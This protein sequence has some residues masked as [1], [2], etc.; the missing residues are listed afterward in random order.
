MLTPDTRIA[1]RHGWQIDSAANPSLPILSV[2]VPTLNERDN[3]R[4]IV[5]RI[6]ASLA[7]IAWEVVFVDDD[8]RDGTLEVLRELSRADRRV[9][10]L[11][12]IGRRGLSSAVCEGI[13]STST[14]FVAVMDCDLQ[15][16][17]AMLPQMLDRLK[18]T[19]GDIVVASRYMGTGGVGDLGKKRQLTSL[20]AKKVADLVTASTLTDPLS[21]FFV[22][23]REAFDRAARH[24]TNQGYKILL[25]ILLSTR[26]APRVE[27]MPYTFRVRTSGE[28]KLTLLIVWEYMILLIDKVAGHIVPP[29]FVM[30]SSVGGMGLIVHMAA[31][32]ILVRAIGIDFIAAQM[33]ATI[34]AMTFN[35]FV[36]NV[37]T[38]SDMRLKGFWPLARG[39]FSFYLVCAT[40][41]VANVGIASVLFERDYTWWLAGV[42]GVLV[43]AVWN[44]AT[45]SIFTWRK[46]RD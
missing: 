42:A 35:F 36:N 23:R 2:I 11:H 22:I 3:V 43:G 38:Y 17:E 37:L 13:L 25:D 30:F 20:V 39:L 45:T 28:S 24:L 32:A 26:P 9:R 4:E 6:D 8:S 10:Y 44:Y 15:H 14:P 21:G 7:G 5:R 19:G 1:D 40:G 29:R 33:A 27:E 16:D 41:A 18:Q 34:V 12:R 46:L 31:L